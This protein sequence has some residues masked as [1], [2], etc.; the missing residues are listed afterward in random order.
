MKLEAL[1]F[2]VCPI[3]KGSLHLGPTTTVTE[4]DVLEGWLRCAVCGTEYPIYKGIPV[5][6]PKEILAVVDPLSGP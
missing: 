5:L 4:D 3:D 1:L 6:M 2:L